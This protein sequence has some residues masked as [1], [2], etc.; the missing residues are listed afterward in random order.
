MQ[1][2]VLKTPEEYERDSGRSRKEEGSRR[3]VFNQ[4]DDLV[5]RN[6]PSGLTGSE[7]MAE[8]V[9]R[10][11]FVDLL[12]K[13]L[14]LDPSRRIKPA[15]VLRHPFFTF[16]HMTQF[17]YSNRVQSSIHIMDTIAYLKAQAIAQ[18]SASTTSSCVPSAAAAMQVQS[19]EAMNTSFYD[20]QHHFVE[21]PPGPSHHHIQPPH[22]QIRGMPSTARMSFYP[23][24][25]M[26]MRS[27]QP[28]P[29]STIPMPP[30][31]WQNSIED[32]GYMSDEPS[33]LVT[34]PSQ[35]MW[36]KAVE[37]LP[38][39]VSR[40]TYSNQWNMWKPI[41]FPSW[42]FHLSSGY[43]SP[44]TQ[45]ANFSCFSPNS[46]PI[47][48]R[49]AGMKRTPPIFINDSPLSSQSI[50]TI[51]SSSDE[52]DDI[53]SLLLNN[54]NF[55]R[56]NQ[57]VTT[58]ANNPLVSQNKKLFLSS[59]SNS[60]QQQQQQHR[61]HHNGFNDF[62][63]GSSPNET[64]RSNHSILHNANA[65]TIFIPPAETLV[66]KEPCQY[67]FTSISEQRYPEIIPPQNQLF[68]PR[69]EITP[70]SQVALVSTMQSVSSIQQVLPP[71]YVSSTE[72]PQR[73]LCAQA[74][75]PQPPFHNIQDRPTQPPFHNIPDRRYI[76]NNCAPPHHNTDA[77][78]QHN[79][80][81]CI[82]HTASGFPPLSSTHNRNCSNRYCTENHSAISPF[83]HLH[84]NAAIN[85]S[86]QLRYGNHHVQPSVIPPSIHR[87][88]YSAIVSTN[89]NNKFTGYS[90]FSR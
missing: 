75:P 69:R 74:I 15:D 48:S 65:S 62:M 57:N 47:T 34:S 46:H 51:S 86:M 76:Q 61:L 89:D 64:V 5:S 82:H 77:S 72:Q 63:S 3:Y 55:K 38:K 70:P 53:H 8:R 26:M 67:G 35:H 6:F 49:H 50:I 13:M 40:E 20:Q 37:T 44:E 19:Y 31:S 4:L 54:R 2:W 1:E 18:K 81:S 12:K 66:K 22:S 88:G 7:N 80:S 9:D 85:H 14:D 68:M 52:D 41:P 16:T 33:P 56:T 84:H 90:Y 71:C 30:S 42:Q 58:D 24:Q 29:P 10:S 59:P 11:V 27:Q 87:P 32:V 21:A 73:F 60:C 45:H 79:P 17:Y 23:N 28:P 36:L 43:H 83:T 78:F 25:E 39:H